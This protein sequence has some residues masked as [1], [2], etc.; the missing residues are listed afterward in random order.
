MR[1][2]IAILIFGLV[3]SPVYLARAADKTAGVRPEQK[4]EAGVG[5]QK[6]T[7]AQDAVLPA[8]IE[9]LGDAKHQDGLHKGWEIGK[10]LG[11]GKQESVEEEKQEGDSVE[12][13][14]KKDKEEEGKRTNWQITGQAGQNDKYGEVEDKGPIAGE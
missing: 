14:D 5:F 7:L 12:S 9:K 4:L 3:L 11:W 13:A 6:P 1:M 10:H 2:V 8:G